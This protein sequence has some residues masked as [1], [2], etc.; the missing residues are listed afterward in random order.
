LSRRSSSSPSAS[1]GARWLRW[2]YVDLEA[3][4]SSLTVAERALEV[5]DRYHGQTSPKTERGR[6]RMSLHPL[7]VAALAASARS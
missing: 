5:D 4:E 2:P 6:R 7:L 3:E 1:R